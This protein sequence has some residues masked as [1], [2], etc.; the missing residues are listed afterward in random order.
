VQI[1]L[2]RKASRDAAK[3][4]CRPHCSVRAYREATSPAPPSA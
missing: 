3:S 2:A 4:R 1:V